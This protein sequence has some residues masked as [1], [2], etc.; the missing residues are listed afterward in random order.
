[1]VTAHLADDQLETIVMRL[2]RSSGVGGLAAIRAHNGRN[3]RPLPNW[4]RSEL[5]DVAL[6]N[7]LPLVHYTSNRDHRLH[8]ALPH[9]ALRSHTAHA[10]APPR[11]PW[12][13]PPP[14]HQAPP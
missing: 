6:E 4:R 10:P 13:S 12:G 11:K 7:A 2:N 9:H 14:D 3:L 5:F 8:R 1:M